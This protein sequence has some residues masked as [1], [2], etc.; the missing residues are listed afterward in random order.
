MLLNLPALDHLNTPEKIQDFIDTQI[1]YDPYRENR[2]VQE[3]ITDKQAE[4]YNG[5]LL[6]TACLL[7]QGVKASIIEI[8]A[9]EDEEHVLCVYQQNGKYGSIAQSKFLGLKS[10]FP[11]YATIRDLVISYQEFYFS[12][13]GLLSLSSYTEPLLLDQY[14]LKWLIDPNT[15]VQ[16]A[17]DLR[18]STHFVLV[19]PDDP[20]YYVTPERFWR[21]TLFIPPDTQIPQFYLDHKPKKG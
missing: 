1:T 5:A 12:F 10:R 14:Q 20:K 16:M 6:A 7:N 8:L 4:C 18:Q 2:S 19:K 13:A 17:Q 3:V 21:E 15:V 9:R 11:M